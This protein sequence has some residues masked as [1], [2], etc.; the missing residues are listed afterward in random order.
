MINTNFFDNKKF[1]IFLSILIILI[2][3][4]IFQNIIPSSKGFLG[5]DYAYVI[6]YF[7]YGKFWFINNYF[8]IPWFSPSFCCGLP[9]YSDPQSMFYSIPQIIF[10]VFNDPIF[11]IKLTFFLFSVIAFYG[12][13]LLVRN[14]FA[15][16]Y[17][18]SIFCSTLF[19]FNGYFIGRF[20][21]GHIAYVNFIFIPLYC[22]FLFVSFE[23]KVV[24]EKIFYFILSGLLFSYF[25]FSGSSS[26][27]PIITVSIFFIILFYSIF[28]K[29]L[30]II[31]YFISSIIL[32]I[33]ISLSKIVAG[34]ALLNKLPRGYSQTEFISLS[35]FFISSIKSFFLFP[36]INY[37]NQNVKSMFDL[38]FHEVDYN[39]GAA[40]LLP[41]I[42]IFFISK[43]KIKNFIDRKIELLFL[44]ILLTI[45]LLM[46]VNF[47][48]QYDFFKHLPLIKNSWV[49][50]RWIVIYLI[51]V[52]LISGFLLKY[53][54]GI[55]K[56]SIYLTLF[57]LTILLSQNIFKD[58]S[59]YTN[60]AKY[61]ISNV[62]KEFLKNKIITGPALIVNSSTN[63]PIFST[64]KNDL[65]LINYSSFHCYNPILGYGL[66]HLPKNKIRFTNK[67]VI[68]N[69]HSLIYA[70]AYDEKNNELNFFNPVCYQFPEE[71][72]CKKGDLFKV[73]DKD[74]MKKF[75]SYEKFDFQQSKIQILSNYTSLFTFFLSIAY[76]IIFM[77]L[78]LKKKY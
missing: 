32:G 8:S 1:A 58:K 30:K 57:C 10:L 21:T 61:D 37:F 3:Q 48:G 66:E 9:F 51:P 28:K 11:S 65:F 33:L 63:K 44:L 75:L 31:N 74:K 69:N 26:I 77:L 20:L 71:N 16:N 15:F 64:N 18:I 4:L 22:F 19:L 47:L 6:P 49:Q 17:L 72:G 5:H 56:G 38:G 70:S 34:I 67:K 23:K 62:K 25:I 36:D 42:F 53:L 27:V 55:Y 35:S 50:Y 73:E 24:K 54:N 13:F 52:I 60:D 43:S 59:W 40:V 46:N 29:N 78:N 68:S 14:I 76:I 7:I 12:T 45:P 41:F 2:H 39:L